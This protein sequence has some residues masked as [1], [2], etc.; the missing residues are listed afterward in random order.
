MRAFGAQGPHRL[1]DKSFSSCW[2]FS[3]ASLPAGEQG[4]V[5]IY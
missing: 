3:R 2:E 4:Q 5:F 1:W